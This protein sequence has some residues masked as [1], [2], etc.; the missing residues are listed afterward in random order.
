MTAAP[1][2]HL[3]IPRELERKVLELGTDN[4][5]ERY[6]A[7]VLP[8]DELLKIARDELFRPFEGIPR[9]NT[10]EARDAMVGKIKHG[11]TCA[12]RDIRFE[13]HDIG[14]L[15][16]NEWDVLKK[17]EVGFKVVL[18]HPWLVEFIANGTAVPTLR[19]RAHWLTCA[20]C[21]GEV[22][23]AQANVSIPWIGVLL[24]REYAL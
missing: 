16:A 21:E 9:W 2:Q 20:T 22:V 24:V 6:R 13:I 19:S 18:R 5:R 11:R 10:R 23:R 17:I 8:D 15:T 12:R 4:Q 1:E 3:D 7:G 14:E